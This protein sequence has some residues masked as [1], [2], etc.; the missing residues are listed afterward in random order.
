MAI[1]SKNTE[2][3]NALPIGYNLNQYRIDKI[4]GSGGFGI[5]YL[6]YDTQLDCNVALKEYLPNDIAIRADDLYIHPKSVSDTA[7][8]N[9]GLNCFMQEAKTLAQFNHPNIVRIKTFFEYFNTAYIVMD[10]EVGDSL[11]ALIQDKQTADE[12]EIEKILKPLLDGLTLVH[13]ANFLHRDIKPAN[14]Y[15]RS[16]DNTPVLLDFGSARYDVS[17]RSRSMTAIVTPG[18]APFEQYESKGTMQGAW[19]DI[20]A[21]GAVLYRL[22]SAKAPPE[23]PERIGAIMRGQPDPLIPAVKI[24]KKHYSK[25]LL[26][27]IDWALKINETERPQSIAA[28]REKIFPKPKNYFAV[29]TF[30]FFI[31]IGAGG[32]YYI[33]QEMQQNNAERREQE[34]KIAKARQETE[35]EQIRLAAERREQEEEQRK[36][37]AERREQEE[38]QRKLAAEQREQEEEIAKARQ[39]AEEEQ[40]RLAAERRKQEE[41]IAKARQQTEEEQR[42]LAVERRKQEQEIAKARQKAEADR[43]AAEKARQEAEKE[44]RRLEIERRKQEEIKKNQLRIQQQNASV[45]KL[46]DKWFA[47]GNYSKANEWWGLLCE[48][49]DEIYYRKTN[50]QTATNQRQKRIWLEIRDKTVNEFYQDRQQ[51][52]DNKWSK[53]RVRNKINNSCN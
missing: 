37:A 25:H 10:Y 47:E 6:A 30:L 35:K 36:L 18:Y 50:T 46:A 42:R 32:G 43:I 39:Q 29:I 19:T 51:K 52:G 15:I 5:T 3:H 31:L 14:I 44:Q 17:S 49:I 2:H 23:A 21:M 22:I 20:Y 40:R 27:A 24:G 7:N 26:E 53:D 41:E 13:Q 45:I 28:W 33:I 1:F 34:E 38:E 16:Q 12:G 4:L 9:W 11:D 8:F 48:A